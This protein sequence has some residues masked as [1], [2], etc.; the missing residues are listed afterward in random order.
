MTEPNTAPPAAA[1]AAD[2]TSQSLPAR[3]VGVL[4][5]PQATFA[6]IVARPRW[7]GALLVVTLVT[8][9]LMFGLLSTE[10]GQTAML[11]QQV[12]QSEAFGQ[13]IN[14]QQYAQMERMLPMMRYFVPASQLVMIPIVTMV[15]A[16]ILFAVFN[17][18][19]GGSASFK[20]V[21]AVVTHSGAVTLVQQLFV[22]PL[23]YAR[24]SMSSATN[25][26]VFVPFLDEGH[27]VARFL[28]IIDLFIVW[29]LL[30]LA[31]GLAVLYRRRT[32]PIFWSFMGLYV[33]IA[34]VIAIAIRGASG[35]A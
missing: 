15:V 16:G 20:Q 27:F 11:D 34:L 23:N 35:G 29:W 13:T 12:R 6:R 31:I 25:L 5:S 18:M 30:V 33:I 26:G 14:E 21:A 28:G 17:A 8:C 19:L 2:G 9:G 3:L 10:S 7:F 22:A 24:E 32:S 1:A 4:F